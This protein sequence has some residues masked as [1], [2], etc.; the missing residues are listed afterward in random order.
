MKTIQLYNTLTRRKEKIV[1]DKGNLVRIYSCGLTV[2][3]YAHIGNLRK[4]IFDDLLVRTFKY[5]GYEVKHVMNIT[6]VGHLTSDADEGEDKIEKGARREG[7]TAYDVARHFETSFLEDLKRLNIE[8]PEILCRATEHIDDQINLIKTLEEKG[9][10]YKTSDGVYFDTSKSKD[11]GKLARLDL[12][13]QKEGARVERNPEKKNPADFA[14]WKFSH[15]GGRSFDVAQDDAKG[16]REMEWPSPWGVGFPGWHIECSAMSTKYL[17]QPFEIHT[18]GVDHIPVHHTNE[19][20]QSEAA[21]DLPLA[22]YWVHSEHLLN[23]GKK[24]AK[25]EGSFLRLEDLVKKGYEPLDFRYLCLSASFQSKLSFSYDSL[26]QAKNSLSKLREFAQ[27]ID[28]K[29][30]IKGE[31]EFYKNAL[32][33]FENA[34]VDNLNTPTAFAVIF[35]S[36]SNAQSKGYLGRIAGDFIEKVDRIFA[37]DLNRDVKIPQSVY[38]LVK[39]RERLRNKGLY[40]DAD[41][42]RRE[43]EDMGFEVEDLKDTT[44]ILQK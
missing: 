22:K 19:I 33:E 18:G 4:Y 40:D 30:E 16:R 14:L 44:R 12:A 17:G 1:P 6:D 5:F 9:Y 34:I 41:K 11:Y 10:T 37:L 2:Y 29:S 39:N 36:I 28:A 35:N 21:C 26:T 3:D 42:V 38:E 23:E 7:M 27:S 25:S 32:N 20:A 13:G 8:K 43:I 24:M 31:G 15:P